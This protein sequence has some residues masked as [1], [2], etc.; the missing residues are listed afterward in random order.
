MTAMNS[1]IKFCLCAAIGYG[2]LVLLVFL[3]QRRMIYAP[4]SGQPADDAVK[5]MGLSFWPGTDGDF[6]GFTGADPPV[7]SRGTVVAFHGNAGSAWQRDYFIHALQPQGY[8]VILA[9]YPGY[10]GRPGETNETAFVDDAITTIK[11]ARSMYGGPIY[12]LGESMGCGVAA[13]AAACPD[14]DTFGLILITPW[15]S[16]PDLA[17]THYWYLP[18]RMLTIDR[19]DSVRNLKSFDRPVAMIIARNDT[20]VPNKHSLRLFH[21]LTAPK[22]LWEFADAGHNSWPTGADAS[23]WREALDFVTAGDHLPD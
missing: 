15:D 10:G 6:R 7:Q 14:L 22:R 16:L 8:R 17:Q 19:F 3:M 5:A 9:E 21:S 11:K 1:L 18:A 23:W 20:V 2:L 12:L 13:A 4:E